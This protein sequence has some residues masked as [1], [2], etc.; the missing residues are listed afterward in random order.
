MMTKSE[1]FTQY[2]K[3]RSAAKAG[4]LDAKRVDRA[5]GVAQ[6][7][8]QPEYLTTTKSCSCEDHSR[9]PA[10]AC[11]HMIAKMI[12]VKVART[13]EPVKPVKVEPKVIYIELEYASVSPWNLI[14]D[15][16]DASNC[17]INEG[18]G[19]INI[20]SL[21]LAERL[22]GFTAIKTEYIKKNSWGTHQFKMWWERKE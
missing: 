4:K 22:D 17:K 3:A 14:I 1:I 11:K 13:H 15:Y 16:L 2:N 6:L 20:G 8:V 10:I 7:K 19:L 12:E 9:H 18:K 21:E 5:L